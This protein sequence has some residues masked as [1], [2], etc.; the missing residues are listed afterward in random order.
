MKIRVSSILFAL[1]LFGGVAH[2]DQD[3]TQVSAEFTFDQTLLES[4]AGAAQVLTDLEKQAEKACRKVSLV[5][6]GLVVDEVCAQD[7]MVQ[8]VDQIG[9]SNL[10]EQYAASSYYTDTVSERLQLAAR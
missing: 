9:H 7:L 5:T 1:S 6:V 4:E 3:Y 2:A 10:A 8:A